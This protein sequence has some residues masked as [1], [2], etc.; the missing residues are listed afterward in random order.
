[1]ELNWSTFA[2]E[3][4]NFLVLLWILKRFLYKPVLAMIDRRRVGIEQTQRNAHTLR[5]DAEA[6]SEQYRNRLV[7]WEQE[8]AAA[9]QQLQQELDQERARLMEALQ[10]DLEQE[11]EKARVV[12]QR[13]LEEAMRSNQEAALLQGTQFTARLLSRFAGPEVE[14]RLIDLAVEKMSSL[15]TK[16]LDTVRSAWSGAQVPVKVFTAYDLDSVQRQAL[17]DALRFLV[18]DTIQC[19]FEQQNALI[20]G[21]RISIGPWILHANLQDELKSFAESAYE[22]GRP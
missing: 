10:T 1:M 8:R 21:L 18:N 3:I 20:A 16:D 22:P 6:L 14:A 12:E 4:I 7:V 19:Q 17:E 13:R 9:R 2:L 15:P 11:R 5:A